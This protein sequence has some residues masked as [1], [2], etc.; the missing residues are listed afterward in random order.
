MDANVLVPVL[1]RNLIL[2]LAERYMFRIRW[3]ICV[4]DEFERAFLKLYPT[5]APERA[6]RHRDAMTLA[7]QEACVSDYETLEP[8]FRSGPDPCDAHVMAAAKHCG[9]V[10]IV[11]DN[12]AD[13]PQSMLRPL[14]LEALSADHFIADA[15]DLD[16]ELAVTAIREMRAR[17][18]KLEITSDILLDRMRVLK[19]H[20]SADILE[21]YRSQL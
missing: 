8:A 19:L 5:E 14:G 20:Q 15:I 11:I 4:L 9:A 17:L 2:L 6:R 10:V 3:S 1:T 7:F 16:Q 12:L 13:F 21:I 18:K